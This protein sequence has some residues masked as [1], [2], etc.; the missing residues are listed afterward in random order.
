[1]A[2]SAT[3]SRRRLS[4]IAPG[5]E[6]EAREARQM[7]P[8]PLGPAGQPREAS[9][10]PHADGRRVRSAG[11]WL[12]PGR[13]LRVEERRLAGQLEGRQPSPKSQRRPTSASSSAARERTHRTA[14]HGAGQR[15]VA[16]AVRHDPAPA[17]EQLRHGPARA[18][19]A[20]LDLARL[21]LAGAGAGAASGK[22]AGART[23]TTRSTAPSA[24]ATAGRPPR[25]DEAGTVQRV[26]QY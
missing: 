14:R 20:A 17:P 1:M 19:A 24:P 15:A 5:A 13:Q 25:A 18:G 16:Q 26:D 3:V 8:R 11:K 12:G 6:A 10:S 2:R 7:R 22:V 21:G 23:P 9:V 4:P